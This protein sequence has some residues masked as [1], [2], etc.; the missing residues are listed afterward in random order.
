MMEE[1]TT[2]D[3]FNPLDMEQAKKKKKKTPAQLEED[4]HI[5]ELKKWATRTSPPSAPSCCL[6]TL[7]NCRDDLTAVEIAPNY[8]SSHRGP[9]VAASF[10]DST[11]KCWNWDRLS[12]ASTQ[13][14]DDDF[15]EADQQQQQKKSEPANYKSLHG[16]YGP[17]YGLNFSSDYRWLLS[18]S[19]DCTARLW[20]VDT[21]TNV[22]VYKGHQF[23]VWDAAFSSFDYLFATASHDRTARIWSTDRVTPIRILAGHLSDVE[24]Q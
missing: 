13:D 5:K 24:V 19:E 6:Y 2:A 12:F 20:N 21:S 1:D 9:I 10:S 17:V 23:A 18:C 7:F 4:K 11:I 15:E 8:K 16:H 14:E 22:V 3:P